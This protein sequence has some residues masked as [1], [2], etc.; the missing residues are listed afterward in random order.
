M[1]TTEKIVESVYRV[2]S[3]ALLNKVIIPHFLKYPLLTKKQ[4][5]FMM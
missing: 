2:T 5:D 4:G 1:S 3:L